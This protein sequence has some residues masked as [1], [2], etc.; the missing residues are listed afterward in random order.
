MNAEVLCMTLP[1]QQSFLHPSPSNN[2]S[3]T[4]IASKRSM[5]ESEI[6][7]CFYEPWCLSGSDDNALV[8][9][10]IIP[11]PATTSMLRNILAIPVVHEEIISSL[12]HKPEKQDEGARFLVADNQYLA[13]VTG[14]CCNAVANIFAT[15]YEIPLENSARKKAITIR[16][17][18]SCGSR[19]K[20]ADMVRS[21]FTNVTMLRACDNMHVE[22]ISIDGLSERPMPIRVRR[23]DMWKDHVESTKSEKV[24]VAIEATHV[25]LLD[26]CIR[27][28]L[29]SDELESPFVMGSNFVGIVHDGVLPAGSRVAALTKTG[30]NARYALISPEVLVKVPK[31][32]DSAEVAAVVSTYLPAFQALHHGR[33]Q[34]TKHSVGSLK[35]KKILLTEGASI[36][37]IQA[38]VE[39]ARV[40]EA[41][42]VHIICESR[43][44]S[45]VEIYLAAKPLG[46][47]IE[48]WLP[49]VKGQMDIIIDYEYS[50]N[51]G[52]IPAA[53]TPGGRLVW[54][55]HP[56]TKRP[57]TLVDVDCILNYATILTQDHASIY[58]AF[59]NWNREESREDAK[60]LFDLLGDRRIR[61]KV[62]RF[63]NLSGVRKAHDD[64]IK[65]GV[66]GAII[67]EPWKDENF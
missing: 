44:H 48:V 4:I 38:V 60:F 64:L 8:N 57:G 41:E 58:N 16:E 22:C 55:A 40:A 65:G 23:T 39:L 19:R 43:Y 21:V 12:C 37:E 42:S 33:T 25:C 13:N 17:R 53:L 61:P 54:F 50:N 20:R 11:E 49:E 10:K 5:R 67:C 26:V 59:E 6:L 1:H 51:R 9:E 56:P 31:R 3:S 34:E 35:G 15:T 66:F 29:F 27:S 45:Y 24:I 30:G 32:L 2:H 52:E 62:D 14:V 28:G 47:D 18:Q 36:M 7:Q 63:I 46:V